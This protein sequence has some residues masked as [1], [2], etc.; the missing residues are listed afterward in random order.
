MPNSRR[1]HV[2]SFRVTADEFARLEQKRADMKKWRTTGEWCRA[3]SL[4]VAGA[5]P[6]EIPPPAKPRRQPARRMPRLDTTLLAQILGQAGKIG[7][8]CNQ[9]ARHANEGGD[10]PAAATLGTLADEI[11]A[12]RAA[13]TAILSG[14]SDD[15]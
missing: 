15:N 12:L 10:L 14:D 2:I 11:T 8:N 3:A 4:H 5:G 9:L 13:L 7:S 6:A 1:H